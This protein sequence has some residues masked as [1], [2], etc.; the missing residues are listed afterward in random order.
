VLY[1]ISLII[2]ATVSFDN[3]NVSILFASISPNMT[4]TISAVAGR[5]KFSLIVW[6]LTAFAIK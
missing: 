6:F 1:A 4:E 3:Q 2:L 5:I